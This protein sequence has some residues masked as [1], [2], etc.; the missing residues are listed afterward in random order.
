MKRLLPILFL[1]LGLGSAQ[2]QLSSFATIPVEINADQTSF[3]SGLAVA[4]NNVVIH[5]GETV[6]YCDYAQYNP[7]THDVLVLGNVRIY[8]NGQLFT[9]DRAVYNLETKKL[10]AADFKADIY[11]EAAEADTITSLGP[12]GA[13][14]VTNGIF[15]TSDNSKPDYYLHAKGARIYEGD[16]IILTDVS[17]YVGRTPIM[18]YPYVYQSLN[19]NQGFTVIPGYT[20][21]FGAYLRGKYTFPITQDIGATFNL[22]LMS[23]RGV[24]L[25]LKSIWGGGDTKD[26]TEWG[27]F[28]AYFVHDSDSSL[29]TTSLARETVPSQRYRISLQ[30]RTYLSEDIYSSININK[31]SDAR[32]LQDFV[33][34]EFRTDPNPDNMVSLTKWNEDYAITLTGRKGLNNFFDSTDRLPELAFDGK[35]RPLFGDSGLNYVADASVGEYRRSFAKDSLFPSYQTFRAD[36]FLQIEYPRTYFGWLSVVPSVGI[37]ETYYNSTGQFFETPTTKDETLGDGTTVA[38]GTNVPVLFKGGSTARTVFNADLQS[39]FKISKAWEQVQSRSLGLDGLRNVI[40]PYFDLS[41][42]VTS[43]NPNDLLQFDRINPSTQRA[44]I[45]FPEFNSVDAIEN[46]AILRLGVNNRFQTRRDN[47]T[48]NW[49]EINTYFDINFQRPQFEDL[50]LTRQLTTATS[51]AKTALR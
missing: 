4:K 27:R 25:G 15:T 37:R 23:K 43:K 49:L 5:H 13:Y 36:A 19:K 51:S 7:D 22:D 38:A 39:S 42:V 1:A 40:Q 21:E 45:D 48:I 12:P 29:N 8:R 31:L 6:V 35:I 50:F 26:T 17:V 46:W 41:Y 11:P 28:R 14:R 34:G 18:W 24:G 16:R 3:E 20:S 33:P 44:P 30:D 47:Q 10:T 32:F 2:A 9:G